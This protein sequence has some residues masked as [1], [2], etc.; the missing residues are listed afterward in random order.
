ME[1]KKKK[2]RLSTSIIFPANDE[3][4]KGKSYM[5]RD[6]RRSRNWMMAEMYAESTVDSP[7]SSATELMTP[8][9][10][11]SA[12]CSSVGMLELLGL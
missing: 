11:R 8:K 3:E 9:R 1:L 6:Q 5:I 12:S 10:P 2:T 7:K 4:E